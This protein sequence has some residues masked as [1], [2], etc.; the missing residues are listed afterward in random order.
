MSV[1]C[2][3]VPS[4]R[5]YGYGNC[6]ID[7][8]KDMRTSI[9]SQYYKGDTTI[10]YF[11]LPVCQSIGSY[12][13]QNSS[14]KQILLPECKVLEQGA[15]DSTHNWSSDGIND[16]SKVKIIKEDA[17][18]DVWP[19]VTSSNVMI[20]ISGV[21]TIE[22]DAFWES[23][24]IT[25]GTEARK[26]IL[27]NCETI[28][29]HSFGTTLSN[30]SQKFDYISLPAIK[31][32]GEQAFRRCTISDGFEFHIGPYCTFLN[33]S[34]GGFMYDFYHPNS[35]TW[36]FYIEATTPPV[37]SGNTP[38]ISESRKPTKIYVPAQSVSTYQNNS[39]WSFY[40]DV[41]EAMP[42]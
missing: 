19:S 11:D 37:L 30:Y 3:C 7:E 8:N 5:N 29:R 35:Y 20:D 15:F 27:P 25:Y 26:L 34:L 21:V 41:I 1:T 28:G 17:F 23:L 31:S 10:D 16:F 14:I 13:F 39:N 42:T 32:I 24:N 6:D 18:C 36:Y 33:G 2:D 4:P 40:A 9:P 22:E 12:A 38:R